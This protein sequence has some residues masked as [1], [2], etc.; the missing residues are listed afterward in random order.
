MTKSEYLRISSLNLWLPAA[1]VTYQ[2]FIEKVADFWAHIVTPNAHIVDLDST[3][4]T[5]SNRSSAN[6]LLGPLPDPTRKKATPVPLSPVDRS[7]SPL[8]SLPDLS[9]LSPAASPASPAASIAS[10]AAPI[11]SSSS[12]AAII[13][14]PKMSGLA[15]IVNDGRNIPKILAGALSPDNI[16]TLENELDSYFTRKAM[17]TEAD[18]L[19]SAYASTK[20]NHSLDHWVFENHAAWDADDEF[21]FKKFLKLLRECFLQPNWEKITLRTMVCAHQ[22]DTETFEEYKNRAFRGNALLRN[23]DQHLPE[24]ELRRVLTNNMR[25]LLAEHFENPANKADANDVEMETRMGQWANAVSAIETKILRVHAAAVSQAVEENANKR[26]RMMEA[27]DYGS[28]NAV[29]APKGPPVSGSNAAPLNGVYGGSQSTSN[30]QYGYP[31]GQNRGVGAFRGGRGGRGVGRGGG[32]GGF[33]VNTAGFGDP[34]KLA[35]IEMHRAATGATYPPALEPEEHSSLKFYGGCFNC[36][37]YFQ[38]HYSSNCPLPFCD[39]R[40]YLKRTWLMGAAVALERDG[41]KGAT[42]A[43][44]ADAARNASAAYFAARP[45]SGVLPGPAYLPAPAPEAGVPGP[46]VNN[47]NA[48]PPVHTPPPKLAADLARAGSA[49]VPNRRRSR[50]K[51]RLTELVETIESDHEAITDGV[52]EGRRTGGASAAALVQQFGVNMITEPT[53]SDDDMATDADEVDTDEEKMRSEVSV[54]PLFERQPVWRANLRRHRDSAPIVAE[55]MI[56]CGSGYVI[57]R[58]ALA[59]DLGLVRA[60]L[61]DP[62]VATAAWEG[63]GEVVFTESVTL[64]MSSRCDSYV[65]KPVV[66]LITEGLHAP[67]LLGQPVITHAKLLI[68]GEL[69]T[70]LCGKSGWIS[71]TRIV[72]LS[73]MSPCGRNFVE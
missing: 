55:A 29:G 15:K 44:I 51:P 36:R 3:R 41:V 42:P 46:S 24:V 16:Y 39:G 5:R 2:T 71:S 14:S 63:S 43:A 19:R 17:T 58:E 28:V 67:M 57:I 53:G 64:H 13:L 49:P 68:A 56:D 30:A 8:S 31:G 38:S 11:Q 70:V 47:V 32:R 27:A 66:A 65:M 21:T 61:K 10:P 20:E 72:L 73:P 26:R 6:Q 12:P 18:K 69:K 62:I 48:G 23:T 7:S 9:P 60:K 25:P 35:T 22:K 52:V 33:A 50:V 45:M 54:Q 34:N 1:V 37:Q 4:I 40:G 59:D